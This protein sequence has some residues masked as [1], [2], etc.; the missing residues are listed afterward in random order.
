[1][2][3]AQPL[4]VTMNGGV[5]ICVDC[6]PSPDRP[7]DRAP[8]PRRA[9]RRPRRRAAARRSR[10]GTRAGRCRSACSAT[11]PSSCRSCS[12]RGAPID[13]VTDQT[14]AHDPLT[15]LPVG[16][17]FEDMAAERDK[18]PAGFTARARESMA[19]HVEA[20]VG[21][22][23]AGAEV[24][25][26]GN[27]IRGE[28][29]LAGLRPGVR[30]PRLRARLHPAAVLRGQGPVP[31]GGAVRRPERHRRAPTGRSSS[32]S[33]RTSRWPGG[34]SMAGEKVQFQGL[35]ARICWLGYGERDRAGRAVQRHGRLRRDSGPDRDR[36]RP[37]RLRLASPRPYRETE[38]MADGSDA[39][40]DWP[41]LNAMV[42]VAS[43]AVLGVHPP[44]RRRRHRPVDPRR[45]GHASPTARRWRRRSSSGCSP[46]TPAW[47]SSAT[48]TPA[49][50]RPSEVAAERG[51]RMPMRES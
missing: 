4:A 25:D 7:P 27:S 21:F 6:D 30:L 14:S 12:R 11:P 2:G 26:Y 48:S 41:L 19:R 46:T 34:S 10:P 29:Q 38:A 39:I 45:P 50:T 51:V 22:Q 36:P 13:I 31:L 42:N 15:Y 18:D 40:A 20:M 43:G 32:C 47:A 44:R 49:T 24:F 9:G 33:R 35:P 16:V 28:A 5:A 3:G 1:M 17:A 23:D 8:L 37:P